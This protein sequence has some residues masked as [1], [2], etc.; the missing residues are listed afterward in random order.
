MPSSGR[1]KLLLVVVALAVL[2]AGALTAAGALIDDT[3]NSQPNP[4]GTVETWG[5]LPE[6]RTWGSTSAVDIAPDGSIWVAERCGANT[7]AGS[8]LAP[9][10]RFDSSGKLLKSFGE[11][12][13][14]FPHG[15]FVDHEGNVWITDAQ[16]KDGKGHQVFK[17][18]PEGKILLTLG[19]AG[20]AGDGPD[21]FNQPSDV[22]VA[23]NGDIF[24][25]DGHG[26]NSNARIVK[27]SK[28][29]KFI[30]AWGKKGNGPGEFD[31]PHAIALDSKGRL[32]VGDRANNRV[33]I[34]DQ[35]GK[36]IAEWKQ[37]GRPS[38]VFIDKHDVLYVA[39][40][41]SRAENHPGWKR[42]IR[43]GSATDGVVTAFIPD[44]EPDPDHKPT[45]AAEGVA[46]DASGAVYGAEVGPK[47]VKKYL[48]K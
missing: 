23:R 22:V 24:V 42:G 47:D 28:D 3:P 7:C 18:S 5:K 45:S 25:A 19:K 40:S 38:G 10:L 12:L 36:F 4:Y 41:E 26:G 33:Q 34:F 14:V 9:I 20:V 37:F 39:D 46:A 29:G 35:D 8:N 11:G 48:K 30:K 13:F 21:T 32:F 2:A 6:G 43:V 44:T 31:T 16:G 1:V 17:F 27:F 15:I